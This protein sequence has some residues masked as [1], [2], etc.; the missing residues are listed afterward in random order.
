MQTVIHK[1]FFENTKSALPVSG[2]RQ[3]WLT[4]STETP[5][6]CGDVMAL[7]GMDSTAFMNNPQF[8]WQHQ[9]SGA[10]VSSIGKI[11]QLQV[12]GGALL[13]LA[14]FAPLEINPLAEQIFQLAT[15][16]Y[17]PANSIGFR[18][19]EWENND[20][21]GCTYTKWELVECS[22]VEIPMN[23]EAID[24]S[25]R[26]P[27]QI[28]LVMEKAGAEYSSKNKGTLREHAKSV[29]E[30]GKALIGKA[31]DLEKMLDESE[32]EELPIDPAKD[33]IVEAPKKNYKLK[34][35]QAEML[36]RALN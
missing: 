12:I 27:N 26:R 30:Y 2:P 5:D 15:A 21:G 6:R 3:R 13:A 16:G 19:L 33:T 24:K 1:P 14:E 20:T 31:D 17:L 18:P 22:K 7:A 8:I 29:R 32:K 34:L 11:L 4:M 9:G 35:L 23:P 36:H 25:L 28:E 10:E